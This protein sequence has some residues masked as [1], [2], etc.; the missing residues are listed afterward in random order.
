[1][2]NGGEAKFLFFRLVC[3]ELVNFVWMFDMCVVYLIQN[4]VVDL[5]RLVVYE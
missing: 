3:C 1:M 4:M 5:H 2:G